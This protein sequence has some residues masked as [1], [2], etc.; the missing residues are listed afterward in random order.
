MDVYILPRTGQGLALAYFLKVYPSLVR[1]AIPAH[2]RAGWVGIL[3][4]LVCAHTGM[5]VQSGCCSARSILALGWMGW[6]TAL[7]IL[8]FWREH[9][10]GI[11]CCSRIV[12]ST[13][14][15]YTLL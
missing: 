3:H 10:S 2:P 12:D 8:A 15:L 11:V 5:C 14:V 9:Y 1:Q 4:A 7:G 6:N 13:L